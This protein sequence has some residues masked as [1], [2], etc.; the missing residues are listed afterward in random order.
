MDLE[1]RKLELARATLEKLGHDLLPDKSHELQLDLRDAYSRCFRKGVKGGVFEA[2]THI[3]RQP[4]FKLK[5][6]LANGNGLTLTLSRVGAYKVK[7]KWRLKR[8][9]IKYKSK[10]NHRLHEQVEVQ[11]V[12]PS[13]EG[14]TEAAGQPPGLLVLDQCQE[15]TDRV[16]AKLTVGPKAS[17]TGSRVAARRLP[18]LLG[19]DEV[20]G[21]L[22][23]L[24]RGIARAGQ[25]K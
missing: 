13:V 21:G 11:V 24:F 22:V 3:F 18:W 19:Q 7:G 1:D 16:K 10:C 4:W 5:G 23:W 12:G 2:K 14:L 15:T 8:G 25:P 20:L 9:K 6:R 17:V